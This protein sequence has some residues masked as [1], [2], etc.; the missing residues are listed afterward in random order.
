MK[1]KQNQICY[2]DVKIKICDDKKL[3]FYDEDIATKYCAEFD[4]L[5]MDVYIPLFGDD[6]KKVKRYVCH[7]P[8][9]FAE[10]YFKYKF[11]MSSTFSYS[12]IKI[13]NN[14][15]KENL[16][17]NKEN[18]LQLK[19]LKILEKGSL[20]KYKPSNRYFFRIY[21]LFIQPNLLNKN[22]NILILANDRY[23]Y[24]DLEVY[25]YI[26]LTKDLNIKFDIDIYRSIRF[27]KIKKYEC[28][29]NYDYY[30]NYTK[31]MYY[32]YK[33]YLSNFNVY[34]DFLNK[35]LIKKDNKYNVIISNLRGKYSVTPNF[36]E[37]SNINKHFF[38]FLVAV[39][40]LKNGGNF[41][42]NI[43]LLNKKITCDMIL[44]FKKFFNKYE[45]FIPKIAN[46]LSLSG[47][48]IIF[49]GFDN[50]LYNSD[51]NNK[52][53]N[54]FKTMLK[55]DPT[56]IN[57]NIFNK[58]LRK[59][60]N[61]WK[62]ITSEN[63]NKFVCSL[64][65]VNTDS[66]EYDKFRNFNKNYYKKRIENIKNLIKYAKKNINS[67]NI[68]NEIIQNQYLCAIKYAQQFNFELD[69]LLLIK[70]F[71]KKEKNTIKNNNNKKVNE[72]KYIFFDI[73]E[74]NIEPYL[75]DNYK[76]I[77]EKDL[78][79][80]SKNFLVNYIDFVFLISFLDKKYKKIL[81]KIKKK[82]LNIVIFDKQNNIM[83]KDDLY[84]IVKKD[85]PKLF[86]KHFMQQ[87]VIKN[88]EINNINNFISNNKIYIVKPL[89][90]SK[91][92]GIKTHKNH[93][94]LKKHIINFTYNDEHRKLYK[95]YK[96]NKPKK[97][98]IQEYID[99]PL[100]LENKKF[101][102]RI[103]CMNLFISETE[104]KNKKEKK[105][106]YLYENFLIY[107][108]EKDYSK[109]K[110][111]KNIHN[112]HGEHLTK[113]QK[114]YYIDLYNKINK[115][116]RD[117]IKNQI[118]DICKYFKK[119]MN[120]KC[121]MEVLNCFNYIGIDFMITDKY[122]VKCIEINERPGLTGVYIYPSF[123]KGMLDLTIYK[124]SKTKDYLKL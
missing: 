100:L 2:Y 119:F 114:K 28:T 15:N 72:T 78:S 33:K 11:I 55:I 24:Q 97:W 42:I 110:F 69:K 70:L 39:N 35:K 101:H 117:H 77:K 4:K 41:V 27:V 40:N 106:F 111:N 32:T 47:F 9:K 80:I 22:D 1:Y 45:I 62:D 82:F 63:T 88:N 98:I 57:F 99:N 38:S 60:Y 36:E 93:K 112:S 16:E 74:I 83:N 64:L 44:L 54:I 118:I 96:T 86:N 104:T 48:R 13:L 91:G 79:N 68:P 109:D 37:L 18:S 123:W 34:I 51:I 20:L 115:K 14:K 29:T 75:K 116:K 73:P 85:N 7:E 25:D 103:L 89:P 113:N 90:G 67:K 30:S 43:G 102:L 94:I 108:A 87:K 58:K 92:V 105:E 3:S 59:K 52:I 65:D 17:K 56:S 121:Y 66:T 50:K 21:E 49:Y 84:R 8:F 124:K 46:E 61:I 12:H 23:A 76:L 107:P 10:D 95:L 5:L 120:F 31:K 6:C 19:L 122:E 71:T 53:L 26:S 81:S